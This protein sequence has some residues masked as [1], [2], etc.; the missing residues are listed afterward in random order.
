MARAGIRSIAS[1][2]FAAERDFFNTV[3]MNPGELDDNIVQLNLNGKKMY[4]DPGTAFIVRNAAVVGDD[5]AGA[6]T[7]KGGRHLGA[8]TA[9]RKRGAGVDARPAS[10]S[11]MKA[12][13]EA[14][15]HRGSEAQ[16]FT[17]KSETGRHKPE[18]AT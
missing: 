11:T 4:F 12:L 10:G 5:G 2:V 15:D 18:K 8:G 9:D 3:V 7:V 1:T 14:H 17:W 16:T 6:E 13:Q